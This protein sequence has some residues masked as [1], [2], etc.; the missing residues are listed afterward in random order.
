MTLMPYNVYVYTVELLYHKDPVEVIAI[1]AN[2]LDKQ[3]SIPNPEESPRK[4][5]AKLEQFLTGKAKTEP[6]QNCIHRIPKR[7]LRRMER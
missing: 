3:N 2:E 1:G 6:R 4:T 7:N 5:A